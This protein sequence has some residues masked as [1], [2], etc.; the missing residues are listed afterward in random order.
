[1]KTSL[2]ICLMMVSILVMVISVEGKKK[3]K[4]LKG[5][6]KKCKYCETIKSC[7]GDNC[8]YACDDGC[9]KCSKC[10]KKDEYP[11]KYCEENEEEEKC[12]ERCTSGCKI[13][14]NLIETCN[15]KS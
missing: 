2:S 7:D 3:S 13:C 12:V 1:M 4:V 6:C 11:C 10:E 8:S 5:V 14:K 9:K 15:K